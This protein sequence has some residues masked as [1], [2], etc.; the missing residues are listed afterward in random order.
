MASENNSGALRPLKTLSSLSA[1][2]CVVGFGCGS[3]GTSAASG[4]PADAGFDSIAEA[5]DATADSSTQDTIPDVAQ[6]AVV[7]QFGDDIG[8]FV[9]NRVTELVTAA[10]QLPVEP[11]PA[12]EVP[13]VHPDSLV[14]G[15][16]DCATVR[17]LVP[18][19]ESE[20]LL[21]EA[22]V[23]R[24]GTIGG[25]R[26]LVAD[27]APAGA[28]GFGLGNRGA[29]YGAYALLEELGFAFLHP[30][31]PTVPGTLVMPSLPIDRV[32]SPR[33]RLRGIQ[34]HTMHPLE[35]TDVLNGWGPSGPDDAQG[36]G[37]MLPEW[38]SF[39]EWALANRLN[40][41]HWVLLESESWGDFARGAIRQDRLAKLVDMAHAADMPVGVDVPIS[42]AQQHAFRL[43]TETGDEEAELAQIRDTTDWLMAAGFDYLATESGTSEFT[44]PEPERMLAWMNELASHLDGQHDGA[45]AYMKIHCSTGL[46]AEGYPDPATGED[47]NF[48]FLP[49]FAD[50][51]LGVQPH[52]VQHYA[53]DDPAPTYGNTDFG[54]IRDFLRHEAGL[55]EVVWHP[56]SAYWVSFDIDVPLFLP[57]YADRRVH[58]LRL[59]AKDED[60]GKM[61]LGSLAGSRMDGQ[62]VF[63]SGWEWGYWINDVVAARAAWNPH[64]DAASDEEALRALLEPVARPFGPASADLV[65][66]IIDTATAQQ[67]LLIEGRVGGVP[68]DDI[69]RR[70]GQA[71]LQGAETWDDI[72]DLG[73]AL[74]V[75]AVQMTQPDKLGLVDMRNPLHDPPGY[76]AEVD[77]LLAEMETT[78]TSLADRYDALS[79]QVPDH[80]KDLHD[81]LA[82][83]ARL[84][85]L[86]ATQVHGL[87]DYVDMFWDFDSSAR[88]ARLQTARNALDE[89]QSIVLERETRYRVPADRIAGWRNNPTAYEFTYL[90]TVRS[91]FY[92]WRDEGKAVD[93]PVSP[94]YLN[95]IN[96]VDVG[97]GEGLGVDAVEVAQDVTDFF[98]LG[99]IGDCLAPPEQE[100]TFPQDDLRSRP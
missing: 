24:S 58:D 60:E 19:S 69:L 17:T 4:P 89:A 34:L 71:Y 95:I 67:D 51:R 5:G 6:P 45:R 85:A 3:D 25:A 100:P 28:E 61:G 59:L 56:E 92:W 70:N 79:P 42:L 21:D 31:A 44:H 10:A 74:P 94:C 93:A 36:W 83:A 8:L 40:R 9:R 22:M 91:L 76:S 88:L 11:I 72:S 62:F 37:E 35:L 20:A 41:V 78:F 14:L 39:L 26:L 53:L 23:I 97:F 98:G 2:L 64:A 73:T 15:F 80:S 65:D 32:E 43:V 84:T 54:Y 29:S 86:R 27:G 96:A 52:T 90:W 46:V 12:Q 63:S 16:G 13:A 82:D 66:L 50:P 18:A 1:L 57:I 87:Y 38:A 55:R 30:L 75:A 77:P 47:I 99:A 81:D 48:N 7:L 33:W 68:P 49:H